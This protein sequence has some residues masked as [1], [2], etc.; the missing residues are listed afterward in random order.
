MLLNGLFQW[1][2]FQ[3]SQ[4]ATR[5]YYQGAG[6]DITLPYFPGFPLASVIVGKLFGS[7]LAGGIVLNQLC[8]IAASVLI[9]KLVSTLRGSADRAHPRARATNYDR[10]PK[11]ARLEAGDAAT[12]L[13]AP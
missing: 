11:T 13:S 2:A 10:G 8:T 9:A 4:L 3:Y 12:A 6:Y 5:G 1:D 7:H